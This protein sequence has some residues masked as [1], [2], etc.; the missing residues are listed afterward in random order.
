[1]KADYS[2][3]MHACFSSYAHKEAFVELNAVNQAL[4]ERIRG[5]CGRE[6]VRGRGRGRRGCGMRARG[7]IRVG[8]FRGLRILRSV[9]VRRGGTDGRYMLIRMSLSRIRLINSERL[10]RFH[11]LA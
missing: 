5:R 3:S 4:F 7:S 1:M 8:Y 6:S 9:L 2:Q 11:S 10:I